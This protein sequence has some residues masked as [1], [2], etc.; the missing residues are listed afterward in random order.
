[1]NARKIANEFNTEFRGLTEKTV[2][3]A[4]NF[5]WPILLKLEEHVAWFRLNGSISLCKIICLASLVENEE[6]KKHSNF[7]GICT[8][9]CTAFHWPCCIPCSYLRKYAIYSVGHFDNTRNETKKRNKKIIILNS[10]KYCNFG[11]LYNFQ[12]KFQVIYFFNVAAF[13]FSL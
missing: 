8:E 10:L 7:T 9:E 4:L 6:G 2:M 13:V 5:M 11:L 1:M 12:I 3:H